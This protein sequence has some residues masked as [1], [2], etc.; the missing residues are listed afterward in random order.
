MRTG[1]LALAS[2]GGTNTGGSFTV[3]A[4][5]TLDLTGGST[6]AYQGSYTGS[7]SGEVVLGSGTFA[8]LSELSLI[9]I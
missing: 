6:V 7:G 5:A 3:S 4:G 8:G 9:H 2:A 1:T